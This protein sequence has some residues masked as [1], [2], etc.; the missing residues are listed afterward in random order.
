MR[1]LSACEIEQQR[2]QTHENSYM[3][4]EQQLC[5]TST[6]LQSF[7]TSR[8]IF[9][10]YP[11]T[12]EKTLLSLTRRHGRRTGKGIFFVVF[13]SL[14]RTSYLTLC[15]MHLV[16]RKTRAWSS[17]AAK[18]SVY[19]VKLVPAGGLVGAR[20]SDKLPSQLFMEEK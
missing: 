11:C 7:I 18:L 5:A 19:L 9:Q 13:H 4:H 20:L 1:Q 8:S 10:E 16:L 14:V 15:L 12:L 6:A 17:F 3:K 2:V